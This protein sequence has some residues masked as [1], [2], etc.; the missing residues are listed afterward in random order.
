MKKY[1]IAALGLIMLSAPVFAKKVDIVKIMS[2]SCQ[3]CAAS[4]SA[5]PILE[6]EVAKT[7]GRFI[8]APIP[9]VDTDTGAKE[10]FYYAARNLDSNF[11]KAV[12]R[13]F[14]SAIQEKGI[15]LDSKEAILSLL[16]RRLPD[17][18]NLFDQAFSSAELPATRNSIGKAFSLAKQVNATDTPTYIL[19]VNGEITYSTS[20]VENK[21]SVVDTKN[22]LLNQISKYSKE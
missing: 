14:Y 3:V 1:L 2:F 5:D 18:D 13:E 6:R 21:G 10:A 20:V 8:S 4:E 11:G 16:Q 17:Y 12:K 7:G 15:S 22:T 19:L 9:T